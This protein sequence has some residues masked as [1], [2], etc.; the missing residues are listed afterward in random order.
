[1]ICSFVTPT[2]N[3]IPCCSCFVKHFPAAQVNWSLNSPKQILGLEISKGVAKYVCLLNH[4]VF[5]EWRQVL[6]P[7]PGARKSTAPNLCPPPLRSSSTISSIWIN[8]LCATSRRLTTQ[9]NGGMA[10]YLSSSYQP[11]YYAWYSALWVATSS[12]LLHANT[13]MRTRSEERWNGSTSV[14]S[15]SCGE[16]LPSMSLLSGPCHPYVALNARQSCLSLNVL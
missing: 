5:V 6:P 2:H 1:M 16:T 15:A 12:P 8:T 7:F 3:C 10:Y 14:K 13:T 11:R 4:A 9:S